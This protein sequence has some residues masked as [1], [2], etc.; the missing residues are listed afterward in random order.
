MSYMLNLHDDHHV[1]LYG[2]K[3]NGDLHGGEENSIGLSNRLSIGD[4]ATNQKSR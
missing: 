3:L 4:A 1:T 2:R